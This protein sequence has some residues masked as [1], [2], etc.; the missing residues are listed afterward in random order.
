MLQDTGHGPPMPTIF[1]TLNQSNVLER[2]VLSEFDRVSQNLP[3]LPHN[4]DLDLNLCISSSNF[5]T[6]PSKSLGFEMLLLQIN[7][8]GMSHAS[9]VYKIV[10]YQNI[11]CIHTPVVEQTEASCI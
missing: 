4:H 10:T 2:E 6:S 7:V 3:N 8:V 11:S 1:K 9:F 5:T